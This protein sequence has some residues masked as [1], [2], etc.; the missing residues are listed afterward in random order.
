MKLKSVGQYLRHWAEIIRERR[1]SRNHLV[2]V[3]PSSGLANRLRVM[4]SAIWLKKKINGDLVIVWS[5]DQTL[6]CPYEQ[7]FENNDH[8]K[9]IRMSDYLRDMRTTKQATWVKAIKARIVNKFM[10]ID[11]CIKERDNLDIVEIA[12]KNKVVYFQTCQRFSDDLSALKSF[13]PI[14]Q[15]RKQIDLVAGA[16]TASTIGVHVR[17]TDHDRSIRH[18]PLSLFI[19]KMR[20]EASANA[21]ANFF[22]ATDDREVEKEM[23]DVFGS[24]I[25]THNKEMSRRTVKGIQDA[26]VDLYCLSRTSKIIGS[27]WSSFSEM[28]SKIGQVKLETIEK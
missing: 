26:A 9:V 27:Y 23:I 4:A 20:D 11:Y 17:R 5:P 1:S 13:N 15:I 25:M 24:K 3:E 7:I 19:K 8:F 28:A 22:L 6:N 12:E 21:S 16:F 2:I 14:E 10:G 18:S